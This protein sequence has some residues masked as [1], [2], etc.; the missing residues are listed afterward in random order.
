MEITLINSAF[1]FRF[2]IDGFMLTILGISVGFTYSMY[3]YLK[4][5]R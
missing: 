2:L 4:T 5:F 3:L 1:E